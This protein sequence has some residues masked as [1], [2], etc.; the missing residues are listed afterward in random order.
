MF[1]SNSWG[2][3]YIMAR[4]RH[5]VLTRCKLILIDEIKH[6]I[7]VFFACKGLAIYDIAC[8]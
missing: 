5:A 7:V 1:H 4:D 8:I 2:S 3:F 6:A